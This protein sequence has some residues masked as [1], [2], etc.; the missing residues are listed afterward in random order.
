[1][2]F[3]LEKCLNETNENPSFYVQ[4]AYARI[5]SLEEKYYEGNK[6]KDANKFDLDNSYTKCDKLIHEISKY[7]QVV[8]KSAK[9]LQPHLIIF[10]LKDLAQLFHSYYNDNHV[11]TEDPKNQQL[12]ISSLSAVKQV[13]ANGLNLI[14][15]SPMQK[16]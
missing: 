1:M 13:I 6:T 11:L 9:T 14:G 5:F 8:E 10:Y 3:D 7:P 12:I 15:I 16:M 4:Y 2:I